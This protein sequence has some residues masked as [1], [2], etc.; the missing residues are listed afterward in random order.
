[1]P[2][3][4]RAQWTLFDSPVYALP[5]IRKRRERRWGWGTSP[6]GNRRRSDG[7]RGGE[8][9]GWEQSEPGSAETCKLASWYN[10]HR[11]T[12][13]P[14]KGF[15]PFALSHSHNFP[16]EKVS[17]GMWTL[18][19]RSRR[20]CDAESEPGSSRQIRSSLWSLYPSVWNTGRVLQCA[21]CSRQTE[22]FQSKVTNVLKKGTGLKL[23][24][25]SHDL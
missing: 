3:T 15:S 22:S 13:F 16:P 25:S 14:Q 20:W 7:G 19:R 2:A 11:Q 10:S 9:R 18:R 21:G 4:Q 1:M 6:R 17:V 5:E 12:F 23:D 24:L 8:R